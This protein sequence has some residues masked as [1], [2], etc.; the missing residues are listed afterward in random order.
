M[1][2]IYMLLPQLY[3]VSNKILGRQLTQKLL[4]A[5]V[6][7]QFLGG[8]SEGEAGRVAD[9]LATRKVCSIWNYSIEQDLRYAGFNC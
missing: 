6:A 5:T 1:T 3:N 4:R 7:G 2:H 8:F 9:T